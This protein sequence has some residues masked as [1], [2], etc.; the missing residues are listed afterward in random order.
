V[1]KKRHKELVTIRAISGKLF[2]ITGKKNNHKELVKN[3]E[4]IA[5][6][7]LNLTKRI[8]K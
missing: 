1:A 2:L 6:L 8:S 4:I 3:C 7:F 5:N